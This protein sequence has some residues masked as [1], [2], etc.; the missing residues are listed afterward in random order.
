MSDSTFKELDLDNLGSVDLNTEPTADDIEIV[1]AEAPPS[2]APAPA[3]APNAADDSDEDAPLAD[4][5]AERKRLSR[6]QRL[7]LQRDAYAQRIADLEARLAQESAEKAAFKKQNEEAAVAG[8]DFYLTTLD[9]S[10]ASLRTEFNAAYDSGDRDKVFEIQQKIAEVVAEKKAVERERR[11]RPTKAEPPAGQEARPQT[12][13]TTDSGAPT[14]PARPTA[15]KPNPLVQDWFERNKTWFNQDPI[16]TAAARAID[17]QLV[18]DGFDPADVDY[19]EELDKR[20]AET[21]PHKFGNSPRAEQ[22]KKVVPVIQNRNGTIASGNKIK[23]TVTAADREM[24]RQLGVSIEAY[25]RQ[26]ARREMA[27]NTSNGYTEIE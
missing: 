25:A 8:Y 3:P 17:G 19:F 4:E 12:P 5:G 21:F 16:M 26:K 1:E 20:L 27:E 6:T 14:P 24:A 13:P 11:A 15:G 9:N 7:K 10:L 18:A 23:V 2:P 22:P